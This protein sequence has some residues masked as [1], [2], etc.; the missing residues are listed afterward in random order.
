MEALT[1]E[2]RAAL[3]LSLSF[4]H[5]TRA[6]ARG[7]RE[8]HTPSGFLEHVT[9][10]SLTAAQV[11]SAERTA[12]ASERR[13]EELGCSIL[14][15][16]S[17]TYPKK[18][19]DLADPPVV[20]F[21]QGR[22]ELLDRFA[23]AIVGARRASPYGRRVSTWLAGEMGRRSIA[24]VS[25]LARGIDEAAHRAALETA[26]GSIAVLGTGLDV[27]YPRRNRSLATE[28]RARGLVLT[29]FLPGT[30]PLPHHFPRRNRLVAALS[31]AVLVVEAGTKSGS[32][33]TVDHALDL[34]KPVFGVPGPIDS[35]GSRGVHELLRQ[36]ATLV[37]GVESLLRD[38]GESPELSFDRD[39]GGSTPSSE[40]SGPAGAVWGALVV[41]ATAD[42]LMARCAL[43]V[44][45]IGVALT[46]L[47][48]AGVVG[49]DFD[50]R[51]ARLVV[52]P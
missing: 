19:C 46:E 47:E 15:W 22:L 4:G 45:A 44:D 17:R 52:R 29:E 12:R 33:I 13:A 28:L 6:L 2:T 23:L 7:L 48:L 3:M 41:P 31:Q 40:L 21:A 9:R 25:G 51:Y 10:T 35:A 8:F 27:P 14:P 50:G 30:P 24:I 11:R 34:G 32:F 1:A 39:T 49:R 38:L 26:G 36:G 20:V 5:R 43:G 37:S 16:G 42:E 18:L